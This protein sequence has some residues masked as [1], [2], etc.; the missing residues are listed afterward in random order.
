LPKQQHPI[1]LISIERLNQFS[2]YK[3]K[4]TGLA[5]VFANPY[6]KH[7]EMINN[8]EADWFIY[9][10]GWRFLAK[11]LNASFVKQY[12]NTLQKNL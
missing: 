1:S 5:A 8:S 10:Y 4:Q 12:E 9:Y 11:H 7:I 6:S 2:I 3:L